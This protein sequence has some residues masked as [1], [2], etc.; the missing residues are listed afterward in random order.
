MVGSLS[1][2]LRRSGPVNRG[3]LG[4][5]QLKEVGRERLDRW[6]LV[7]L[8]SLVPWVMLGQRARWVVVN[9]R[10]DR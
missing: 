9:K 6:V 4:L 7:V 2:L 3:L 5:V 10:L 1:H 8:V